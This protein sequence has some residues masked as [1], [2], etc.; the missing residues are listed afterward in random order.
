MKI[1]E[2][3]NRYKMIAGNIL[4]LVGMVIAFDKGLGLWYF[5]ISSVLM[6]AFFYKPLWQVMKFGGDMYY[7]FSRKQGDK[8]YK[9]YEKVKRK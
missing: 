5:L 6:V 7:N 1:K 8:L 4:Y 3:Y 9:Q 2:I